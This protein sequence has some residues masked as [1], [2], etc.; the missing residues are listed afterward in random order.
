[1]M[2]SKLKTTRQYKPSFFSALQFQGIGIGIGMLLSIPI[3]SSAAF[4]L[5]ALEEVTKIRMAYSYLLYGLPFAGMG[6]GYLYYRWE[7]HANSG[8]AVIRKSLVDAQTPIPMRMGPMVLGSTLVAHLFGASVGREG[9]ALQMAAAMVRPVVRFLNLSEKHYRMA[10]TAAI[11][12]GFGAVFGT[13][14]AGLVFALEWNKKQ[15]LRAQ[16]L[17]PACI[18]ALLS[19]R[20]CTAWGISHSSFPAP[21]IPEFTVTY[22]GW[23]LAAGVLFGLLARSFVLLQMVVRKVATTW[24]PFPPLRL[25]WGGVLFVMMVSILHTDRYLGLGL[26]IIQEAFSETLSWED[27]FWKLVLTALVLGV[28]FKGGEVTPLFFMG[29]TMGSALTLV[30]PYSPGL[31][32]A[33]G[34]V[35]VFAGATHTPLAC[36]VMAAELFGPEVL[37]AAAIACAV[38]YGTSGRKTVYAE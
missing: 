34:W 4:F 35:A 25:F 2:F 28:G 5:W 1:M 6:M 12:G 29:G 21:Q 20:I 16:A 27:P 10:L 38:A 26:P 30:F 8:N 18:T 36:I 11:A 19:D 37:P 32:A 3:G 22:I 31:W 9:T 24:I 14:W 7:K 15:P 23:M 13:P 17:L 33:V